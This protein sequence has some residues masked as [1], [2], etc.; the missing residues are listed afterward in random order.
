MRVL[1]PEAV[2]LVIM[3]C[4]NVSYESVSLQNNNFIILQFTFC[5]HV[6]CRR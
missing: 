4:E 6:E 2:I 3:Q 1:L 5:L